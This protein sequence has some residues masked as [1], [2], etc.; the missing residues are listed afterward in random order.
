MTWSR[1]AAGFIRDLVRGLAG[2]GALTAAMTGSGS[3][4]FGLFTRRASAIEAARGVRCDGWTV[5]VTPTLDRA[6]LAR[7]FWVSS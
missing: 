3:A 4:V 7:R 5:R 2:A 1:L 6:S